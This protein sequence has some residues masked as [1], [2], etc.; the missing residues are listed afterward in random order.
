M[1][2]G[3]VP[4]HSLHWMT[5]KVRRAAKQ[6]KEARR[7]DR[8]NSSLKPPSGGGEG[9]SIANEPKLTFFV[10]NNTHTRTH[11]PQYHINK[12]LKKQNIIQRQMWR[13]FSKHFS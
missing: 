5:A 1:N 8:N 9:E 4:L 3:G 7:W 6:Q 11:T 2:K 10:F 12:T 13:L